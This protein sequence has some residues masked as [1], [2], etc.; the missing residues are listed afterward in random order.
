MERKIRNRI[1]VGAV[2]KLKKLLPKVG[3]SNPFGFVFN[4]ED[5][6][7]DDFA[8][9]VI[10]ST[11]EVYGFGVE[12]IEDFLVVGKINRKFSGYEFKN[13]FLVGKDF[14]DKFWSFDKDETERYLHGAE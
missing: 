14:D 7:D 1:R 10:F 3:E 4:I 6:G 11:G 8:F 13:I 12:E 2:V 9:Q 5:Y